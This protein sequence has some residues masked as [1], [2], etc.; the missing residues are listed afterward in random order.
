MT[1]NGK[2]IEQLSPTA[3]AYRV[4]CWSHAVALLAE[5]D[6]LPR[7]DHFPKRGEMTV[8]PTVAEELAHGGLVFITGEE[9]LGIGGRTPQCDQGEVWSISEG[10]PADESRCQR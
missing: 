3:H 9:F 2:G 4:R 1:W 7:R 6:T 5:D 10:E 8:L